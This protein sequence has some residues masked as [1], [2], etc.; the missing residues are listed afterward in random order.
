MRPR[1]PAGAGPC[2]R[3][4]R[5]GSCCRS[6]RTASGQS[7]RFSIAWSSASRRCARRPD[8][9]CWSSFGLAVLASRGATALSGAHG[10]PDRWAGVLLSLVVPRVR[11]DAVATG[12]AAADADGCGAVAGVGEPGPGAVVY[13]PVA[14]D[15]R[16]TLPMVDSL[17]HSR[18][19]VNGDR[20]PTP[21]LLSG[22]RGHDEHVPVGRGALDAA[23]SRRPL[24][25][26]AVSACE[27]AVERR[28][29]ARRPCR[30][31][32]RRSSSGH[33]L[34]TPSS[35]SSRGRRRL[36]RASCSLRHRHRR[37]PAPCRLRSAS[38]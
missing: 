26:R 19:L 6:A 10:R 30:S 27:C 28:A 35:T 9:P 22:A 17:Q 24:H 37:R 23:R 12:G 13:L 21:V 16:D 34:P 33:D 36:N 25:R 20:G 5:S 32:T 4:R 1:S 2:W 14:D 29:P 3:W 11:V 31:A 38:A 18:P 7:T 8:S 15:R